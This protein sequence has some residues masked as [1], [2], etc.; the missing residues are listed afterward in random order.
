MSLRR[1]SGQCSFNV[2]FE[3]EHIAANLASVVSFCS[4][5][6]VVAQLRLLLHLLG[7]CFPKLSR[8]KMWWSMSWKRC[9]PAAASAAFA[10]PIMRQPPSLVRCVGDDDVRL[11][12]EI[13]KDWR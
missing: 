1:K 6:A 12:T 11:E 2:I 13:Y 4:C 8:Q 5:E 3:H 9:A 7:L 10:M